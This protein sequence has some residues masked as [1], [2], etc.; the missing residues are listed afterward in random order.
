MIK[1]ETIYLSILMLISLTGLAQEPKI[2]TVFPAWEEGYL[3]IH[4]INSGK[5]K[6]PF[7]FF[8]MVLHFWLTL[9]LHKGQNQE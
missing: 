5:G 9:A 3:D 8:R 4:H 1:K 6:A 7:L 2:G